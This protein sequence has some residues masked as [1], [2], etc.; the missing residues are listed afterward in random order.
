MKKSELIRR[1]LLKEDEVHMT[2]AKTISA[3]G[4]CKRTWMDRPG[5]R[6]PILSRL[7]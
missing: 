6:L 7:N 5:I 3:S 4:G 1:R 2:R